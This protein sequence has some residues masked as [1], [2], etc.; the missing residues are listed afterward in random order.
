MVT[1]GYASCFCIVNSKKVQ[2]IKKRP[3]VQKQKLF[4]AAG[5]G[6]GGMAG[7]MVVGV[8]AYAIVN[9]I[10]QPP[11]ERK[12]PKPSPQSPRQKSRIHPHSSRE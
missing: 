12:P 3:V 4:K 8:V 9:K 11:T 6:A 5:F 10:R 7:T 2:V 1:K